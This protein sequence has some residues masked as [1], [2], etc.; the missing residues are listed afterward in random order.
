ML[1]FSRIFGL[2]ILALFIS[3]SYLSATVTHVYVDASATFPGQGT[4]ERPYHEICDA[5][6]YVGGLPAGSVMHVHVASGVYRETIAKAGWIT[7]EADLIIEGDVANPP[8]ILGSDQYYDWTHALGAVYRDDWTYDFYTGTPPYNENDLNI[9]H[10]L[11]GDDPHNDYRATYLTR[12][13]GVWV[14][15]VRLNQILHRNEAGPG[16]FMVNQQLN[17]LY[18]WLE[19][20]SWPG[21][22]DIEVS[23]REY[24]ANFWQMNNVT[25]RN[26]EFRYARTGIFASYCN[27]LT[28]ENCLVEENVHEGIAVGQM[29]GLTVRNTN[30]LRNGFS[31]IQPSYTQNIVIEDVN[32]WENNWRGATVNAG[33]WRVAGMKLYAVSDVYMNNVDVR[34][35]LTSGIWF[36]RFCE[37]VVMDDCKMVANFGSGLFW[38]ISPGPIQ[39]TNCDI[40]FNGRAIDEDVDLITNTSG[41]LINSGSYLSA[42]NCD[43]DGNTPYNMEIANSGRTAQLWGEGLQGDSDPIDVTGLEIV[44]C[45]FNHHLPMDQSVFCPHWLEPEAFWANDITVTPQALADQIIPVQFRGGLDNFNEGGFAVAASPNPSNATI[46]LSVDLPQATD[47]TVELYDVLGRRVQTYS[48]NQLPQGLH[49]THINGRNL[50]SG[51]YFARVTAGS[52]QMAT[53][54]LM[55]VK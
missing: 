52:Q 37:N 53:H 18:L 21:G 16:M 5:F 10:W 55:F 45:T 42:I 17:R 9:R 13:E 1:K 38:E 2:S 11:Y 50:A 7:D 44:S 31:G 3:T 15:E 51:T 36:D 32:V 12:Y 30:V 23:V 4:E 8:I 6:R 33:D 39:M 26:L 41:V 20:G 22:H 47:M 49:K 29:D 43:F 54:K 27:T 48:Y 35:N 14:D 40:H 34:N 19:D 46:V 25:L 28:V 24:G